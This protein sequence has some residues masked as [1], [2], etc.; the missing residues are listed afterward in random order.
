MGFVMEGV[1]DSYVVGD[2]YVANDVAVALVDGDEAYV[3]PLKVQFYNRVIL[4]QLNVELFNYYA[5]T[6]L[7]LH[8]PY[9]YVLC[10][11]LDLTLG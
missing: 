2:Y 5:Q 8:G 10:L 4:L 6:S 1:F 7:L 11:V 9:L 3:V